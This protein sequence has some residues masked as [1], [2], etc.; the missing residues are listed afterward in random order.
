MEVDRLEDEEGWGVVGLAVHGSCGH[1]E[2]EAIVRNVVARWGLHAGPR[3]GIDKCASY[4]QTFVRYTVLMLCLAGWTPLH[5]AAIIS[6]PPLISF[7]LTRGASTSAETDRGLTPFDLVAGMPGREEMALLL[8]DLSGTMGM[9]DN[10][11]LGVTDPARRRALAAYRARTIKRRADGETY[12]K[13]DRE[14]ADRE[15]WLRSQS[16][17]LEVDVDLLLPRRD[18]RH[19]SSDLGLDEDEEQDEALSPVSLEGV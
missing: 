9:G 2:K 5:L 11:G 18:R 8:E 3:D 12:D 4:S 13:E 16:Q 6:T 15:R 17:T 19:K 14:L 7:L 1:R 10:G